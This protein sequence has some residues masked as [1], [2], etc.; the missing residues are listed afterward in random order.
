M[1]V[2]CI[3]A[4]LAPLSGCVSESAVYEGNL[5][6]AYLSPVGRRLSKTELEQIARLLADR[7][8]QSIIGITGVPKQPAQ[9]F[10][11]TEFPGSSE[12]GGFGLFTLEK[13]GGEWHIIEGGEDAEPF[14]Q[15]LMGLGP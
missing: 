2:V 15:Q 5:H 12:R 9:L 7:T 14:T 11:Y 3:L 1:R 13:N 8:R 10:V 4:C 6:P